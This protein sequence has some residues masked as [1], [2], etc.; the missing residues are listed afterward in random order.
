M[1]AATIAVP[2]GA[3]QALPQVRVV[4]AALLPGL[5]APL[6][7]VPASVQ[8]FSG[9]NLERS[10]QD[11]VAGFLADSATGVTLSAAQ[12]NQ[13]Q[14]DL[15][16][17]G[18]TASPLLGVPQGLSVY[19]DGVRLN[20]PFGDAVN[21]DLVPASA[22]AGIELVPGSNPLYGLNTL[23]G[24][25][26]V[27]TWNGRTHPGTFVELGRGNFNRREFDA[28]GGG[29]RGRLDYFGA[30]NAADD[31]GWAEHNPS[32]VRRVFGKLG[33]RTD[34]GRIEASITGADNRLSGAQT[35]PLSF[36]D[37]PREAY[38][39]PDTNWNRL[40][41]ATLQA[42]Q[43]VTERL[44]VALTAYYRRFHNRNFASNVNDGF[45]DVDE[46]DGS[47]DTIQAF[48]DTAFIAQHSAG[49]SG[50]ATLDTQ[51]FGRRNALALGASLDVGHTAYRQDSQPAGFTADRGTYAVGDFVRITDAFTRNQYRGA[52]LSDTFWLSNAW[53]LTMSARY[54]VARLDIR[55]IGGD[56]PRLN[57]SHRF[58][59][60]NPSAGLVW[61]P[62]APLSAYAS[63]NQAARAPTPMELTCADPL[64]PCKLP[65][66]FL[67]DP[68][69][70]QVVARTVEAGLRGQRGALH[71]N[72]AAYRSNLDDDIQFVSN[73]GL[74][75]N[76]GYFHNVGRTRRQGLDLNA[77][78]HAGDWRLA[79]GYAFVD[80]T[81]QAAFAVNSP[82]NTEAGPDGAVLVRPGNRIPA[83]PRH[84]FKLA[85]RYEPGGRW[86]LGV[87]ASYTGSTI[88]RGDENNGDARGTVPG[89]TLVG[90]DARYTAPAHWELFARVDN[91]LGRSYA[92]LGVL[93]MNA[94]ATPDR[95]FDGA[96]PVGEPF[97]GLGT[98]RTIV[99]GVRY[100]WR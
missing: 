15:N 56:M 70:K 7:E 1:T 82:V 46:N 72:A 96:H 100:S 66:A 22:I 75:S 27:V 23:G 71:W 18:F 12:G 2:A 6:G 25:L 87:H 37:R 10:H 77:A 51:V 5:D 41:F 74:T 9:R 45:G 85:A 32:R 99:A 65:N 19:Q 42:N 28:A 43:Q 92:S 88:E 59:R 54:N 53:M 84:T 61:R 69:L 8:V 64:D 29:V 94:F 48:N 60:L 50:Q 30:A 47:V 97:R 62:G 26:S 83:I 49:A 78:I 16:F 98:P 58:T 93:G 95:S 76:A 34:G 68:P 73:G 14:P 24:T 86:S 31:D 4:G 57:G 63:F 21:W 39:Y 80:A 35:I 67:A 90:L 81:F 55:D 52:W 44:G 38:T 40:L 20:E 79:A 89:Y 33:Y 11:N 3:Q 17:H 91:L 13:Y 36:I